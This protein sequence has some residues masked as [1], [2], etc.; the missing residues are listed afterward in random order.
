MLWFGFLS[1]GVLETQLAKVIIGQLESKDW[2]IIRPTEPYELDFHPSEPAERSAD[3]V[4][5][6]IPVTPAIRAWSVD[7]VGIIK[8]I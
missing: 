1:L 3:D 4:V 5:I 2:D 8:T 7:S 6:T